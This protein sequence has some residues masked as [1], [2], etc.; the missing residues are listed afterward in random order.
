[1]GNTINAEEYNCIG[2]EGWY[3]ERCSENFLI[4]VIANLFTDSCSIDVPFR[5][6]VPFDSNNPQNIRL[7]ETKREKYFE[8]IKN[9]TQRAISG[10]LNNKCTNQ[11]ETALLEELSLIV[12]STSSFEELFI[13]RMSILLVLHKILR[14]AQENNVSLRPA[15]PVSTTYCVC[16][17][18]PHVEY[19]PLH[20]LNDDER[21]FLFPALTVGMMV[22]RGPDW[23]WGSQD[24]GSGHIGKVV[25][26]KDWKG[27]PNVGVRV[28]WEMG[29]ANVYRYGA[30]NSY[31]VVTVDVEA[32]ADYPAAGVYSPSETYWSRYV[33]N[34]IIGGLYKSGGLFASKIPKSRLIEAL[35]DYHDA[36]SRNE[37]IEATAFETL[38]EILNVAKDDTDQYFVL[39]KHK[40]GNFTSSRHSRFARQ[41]VLLP[42]H[43]YIF[44]QVQGD[45]DGSRADTH[46]LIK[47]LTLFLNNCLLYISK[48]LRESIIGQLLPFICTCIYMG[49][50]SYVF[51]EKISWYLESLVEEWKKLLKLCNIDDSRYQNHDDHLDISI[52][53]KDSYASTN[54]IVDWYIS[55]YYT[56]VAASSRGIYIHYTPLSPYEQGSDEYETLVS[57]Y[58]LSGGI[59][60]E[61][62]K[63]ASYL[64]LKEIIDQNDPIYQT[65]LDW[66]DN[67]NPEPMYK[68]NLTRYNY[69]EIRL[70]G[71]LVHLNGLTDTLIEIIPKLKN[72][73]YHSIPV[74]E[75]FAYLYTIVKNMRDHLRAKKQELAA[76][77][78]VLNVTRALSHA[79]TRNTTAERG[80]F[81]SRAA[82]N[83]SVSPR[84]SF[85]GASSIASN[86]DAPITTIQEISRS[87]SDLLNKIASYEDRSESNSTLNKVER[88]RQ[89]VVYKFIN[90]MTMNSTPLTF[91]DYVDGYND[92]LM[93]LYSIE[94]PL[95][96]YTN[97]YKTHNSI[98]YTH[99][100]TKS[101]ISTTTSYSN[102]S[103]TINTDSDQNQ[104]PKTLLELISRG[105]YN[106]ITTSSN[107]P[108]ITFKSLL[109]SRK[110][111]SDQR[112]DVLTH[113]VEFIH[114][115]ESN[116]QAVRLYLMGIQRALY[117]YDV[118]KNDNTNDIFHN[119]DLTFD[120]MDGLEGSGTAATVKLIQ[121]ITYFIHY[122]KDLFIL[123]NH[124]LN[125]RL[126]STVL[127]IISSFYS[128][129]LSFINYNLELSSFFEQ[130]TTYLSLWY[131]N[132]NK[133][134]GSLCISAGTFWD[135]LSSKPIPFSSIP[136]LASNSCEKGNYV[137]I[138]Q[139][140]ATGCFPPY[141]LAL[142]NSLRISYCLLLTRQ[143]Q[144]YNV[145]I[146]QRIK[147]L[148]V[149]CWTLYDVQLLFSFETQEYIDMNEMMIKQFLYYINSLKTIFAD[150]SKKWKP[151]ALGNYTPIQKS[152]HYTCVRIYDDK[153]NILSSTLNDMLISSCES[154]LAS[155][156]SM[157]NWIVAVYRR[158]D[159]NWHPYLPIIFSMLYASPRLQ[160]LSLFILQ[161]VLPMIKEPLSIDMTPPETN[162][163]RGSMIMQPQVFSSISSTPLYPSIEIDDIHPN[164]IDE[165]Y[166]YYFLHMCAHTS[167]CPSALDGQCPSCTLCC[168]FFPYIYRYFH[169]STCQL[170]KQTYTFNNPCKMNI[171]LNGYESSY[172]KLIISEEVVYLLRKMIIQPRWRSLMIKI[173]NTILSR[174]SE[175]F[176][177]SSTNDNIE[178]ENEDT[179]QLN[180]IALFAMTVA[181]LR[182]LGGPTYRMY[183]GCRIRI[184]E[185][186][187]SSISQETLLNSLYMPQGTGYVIDYKYNSDVALVLF[188]SIT[189]P[190]AIHT[191]HLDVIPKVYM[192]PSIFR[193][194]PTLLKYLEII[195]SSL[196]HERLFM[197]FPTQDNC[198]FN[199]NLVTVNQIEF[200]NLKLCIHAISLLQQICIQC[201]DIIPSLSTEFIHYVV[202]TSITAIPTK[203]MFE[204]PIL[205][206]CYNHLMELLINT[207]PGSITFVPNEKTEVSEIDNELDIFSPATPNSAKFGLDKEEEKEEECKSKDEEEKHENI[208]KDIL[209]NHEEK[210]WK[211]SSEMASI[212]GHSTE[213][214]Y[215]FLRAFQDDVNATI[216]YL[217]DKEASSR[218][219]SIDN[220]YSPY[221]SLNTSISDKSVLND[222][223]TGISDDLFDV[224]SSSSVQVNNSRANHI[225]YQEMIPTFTVLKHINTSVSSLRGLIAS[226]SKEE[227]PVAY[228]P[229]PTGI[230]D[231]MTDK[232][233]VRLSILDIQSGI[234]DEQVC[235]KEDIGLHTTRYGFILN[236]S[237]SIRSAACH[238]ASCLFVME[239]RDLLLI[240]LTVWNKQK[241]DFL[242]EYSIPP[243][244]IVLFT[245]HFLLMY[246]LYYS[247]NSFYVPSSL[248]PYSAP[249]YLLKNAL[250]T[251]ITTSSLSSSFFTQLTTQVWTEVQEANQTTITHKPLYVSSLH[252]YFKKCKYSEKLVFKNAFSLRVIFDSRCHLEDG[253]AI[254][255]FYKES[256]HHHVL[257]RFTGEFDSFYAFTIRGNS[258]YYT[259][260]STQETT[261]HWG[262]A[263]YVQPYE[264]IYWSNELEV[265]TRKSYDWTCSCLDLLLDIG[266]VYEYKDTSFFQIALQNMVCY[267]KTPSLPMKSKVVELLI[268]MLSNKDLYKI[269]SFPDITG[270]KQAILDFSDTFTPDMIIPSQLPQLLEFVCIYDLASSLKSLQLP[271]DPKNTIPP[272]ETQFK[273][274]STNIY[275]RLIAVHILSYIIHY[276]SFIPQQ[277]LH[278]I[279]EQL[280]L[281]WTNE[282]YIKFVT[283][284]RQFSKEEDELLVNLFLEKSEK[285]KIAPLDIGKRNL[286]MDEEDKAR[287]YKLQIFDEE[288]LN[289]RLCLIQLYNI[290]L[291]SVIHLINLHAN[292]NTHDSV[293]SIIRSNS[294]YIFPCV[295]E[296]VLELSIQQTVYSGKDSHPVILLDNKRVFTDMDKTQK[297]GNKMQDT[298][299]NVLNSQSTYAQMYRAFKKIN[300]N[301]LRAK[302]DNRDR[303][304]AVKYQGE[305]GLDWGG[306]YRDAI[307]RCIED[308]F[309]DRMDLFI[310]CPNSYLDTDAHNDKYIPNSKYNGNAEVLSM[311]TFLGYIIGISLRTKH[312]MALEL[313]SIL[314]KY[315]VGDDPCID[316]L[317]EIDEVFVSSLTMLKEYTTTDL[318]DDEENFNMMFELTFSLVDSGGNEIDLIPGGSQ[319]PVTSKNRMKFFQLALDYRLH[320]YK[321]AGE[322]IAKGVYTL[323]SSRALSLFTWRQLERAV[324]GEPEVDV[325]LLRSHTVYSGWKDDDPVVIMFWD[326]MSELSH[327][328]RTQFLRFTWGR[329]KL[330]RSEKWPRPF[331]L[332]KK[333][334]SD[335]SL[336]VA[337]T[338]FF[339]LELPQY[340]SAEIMKERLLVAIHFGS[341]EFLLR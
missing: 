275:D 164:D 312:Q 46:I 237:T 226:V 119:G 301:V 73:D 32:H 50:Y 118:W 264:G 224:T 60:S 205:R 102:S 263:F 101:F 249:L 294:L 228:A 26:I 42:F 268:K 272:L 64:A 65:I 149:S 158:K 292:N 153:E 220:N 71:V 84:P 280:H 150:R 15:F 255:T 82:D 254:L 132:T 18:V 66:L 25:L 154:I 253:K 22:Q 51:M 134:E 235:L 69:I 238:V 230:L 339:Q 152:N 30:E 91:S 242:K 59:I 303:L 33:E 201:P 248:S 341:G 136:Y 111:R 261:T 54:I 156:M 313:P 31:D 168:S 200:E 283:V 231:E 296:N 227:G 87:H 52:Y 76:N 173:F 2:G 316:D 188:D 77:M 93:L 333:F 186:N 10:V 58:I 185:Q 36:V 148:S 85:G 215:K 122:L 217:L 130:Q 37:E 328:D 7:S 216:N 5:K 329:S 273:E 199:T 309:S 45:I 330:P 223:E 285:Q 281:P 79:V 307:E 279:S 297:R 8:N 245:K 151:F 74:P 138:H 165:Y 34:Y 100:P 95:N 62:S 190:R 171:R 182:V 57:S 109:E 43:I 1:M 75:N 271:D 13:K 113:A 302:L 331:K 305:Q 146:K 293:G 39:D 89:S 56:L 221:I 198:D 155:Y 300:I 204:K 117:D 184:H 44:S 48:S 147:Q 170:E 106:F 27:I 206:Q 99:K 125:W 120:F 49:K 212:V 128:P 332:S 276:H 131:A 325:K 145:I 108:A 214:F 4:G 105:I 24:G 103:F 47:Y 222:M 257:A 286:S 244:S 61:S 20:D 327:K 81:D 97:H 94:Q 104:I 250:I 239:I 304:L 129:F 127:W 3:R 161:K 178:I 144:D 140:T 16:G 310:L 322:S 234:N 175:D 299:V 157:L 38:I 232:D 191:Y 241:I 202:S 326:V 6:N 67:N 211:I 14:S 315:I 323:V 86:Q 29:D 229:I 116:P 252:P 68:R 298:E 63:T 288:T 90:S 251:I 177:D 207:Y 114:H 213:S 169:P 319:I 167:C 243:E 274:I 314:W 320:E 55:L 174:A 247:T 291:K 19:C 258:L 110:K 203:R 17:H 290:Y 284:M 324:C 135:T 196:H 269:T 240:L 318:E 194:M 337:H 335:E 336:P 179:K 137:N 311:Y 12:H 262:Y 162:I 23:Q 277:Y 70:F 282:I 126:G 265:V 83:S 334:T 28:E 11:I 193:E 189:A 233:H 210:R 306:L 225:N 308:V 35:P 53:A 317:K 208:Q 133:I 41:Q 218:V 287:Y 192:D 295:K 187:F 112:V 121:N 88:D 123:C 9:V 143:L 197:E 340:S 176:Q 246:R 163:Y 40:Y 270:M 142:A 219:Q 338:C 92:K 278:M 96:I 78:D 115:I 195:L 139:D 159:M 180:R 172:C 256:K 266:Y 236:N 267:L 183:N 80:R 260:E 124:N 209:I 21:H 98:H 259:F 321:D 141:V 72:S 289:I 181:V 160:K 166:I 107:Y